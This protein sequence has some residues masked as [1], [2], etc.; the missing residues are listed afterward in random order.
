MDTELLHIHQAIASWWSTLPPDFEFLLLLPFAI[1]VIGLLA[2]ALQRRWTTR[3]SR[4]A[5]ARKRRRARQA[6]RTLAWPE[7]RA[8][9]PQCHRA[10]VSR[11]RARPGRGM[12][13]M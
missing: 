9:P 1:G 11:S 12:R 7:R 5:E 10:S 2:D 13:A 4:S 6:R 3:W 8:M